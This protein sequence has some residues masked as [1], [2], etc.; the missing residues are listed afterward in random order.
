MHLICGGIVSD[1][2]LANFMLS[3]SVKELENKSVFDEDMRY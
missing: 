2:F 1:C 3:V